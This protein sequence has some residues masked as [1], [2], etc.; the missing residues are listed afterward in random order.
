MIEQY[1][2]ESHNESSVVIS[3]ASKQMSRAKVFKND[4]NKIIDI[5]FLSF[6][7]T[8]MNTTESGCISSNDAE[9][10]K[11]FVQKYSDDVDTI[12]VQCEAGQSRSAGV[13][14]ALMKYLWNNDT[15]IFNNRKY[16][17]NRLCYRTVLN[18]LMK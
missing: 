8:D 14:A 13:A 2:V 12:I 7:D 4:D 5:L 18:E 1:A 10:I 6:N 17:P 15:A 11:Q 3:I 9:S 16:T